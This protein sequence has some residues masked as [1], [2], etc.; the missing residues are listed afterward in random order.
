[1]VARERGS[2]FF[3]IGRQES[4]GKET[5]ILIFVIKHALGRFEYKPIGVQNEN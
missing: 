2:S 5:A 1:M 3:F 4:P